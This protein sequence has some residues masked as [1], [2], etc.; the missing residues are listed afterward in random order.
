MDESRLAA[1]LRA[2]I[3]NQ[4]IYP[5]G[6][7]SVEQVVL[8]VHKELEDGL[9]DKDT[10]AVS[11]NG[12]RFYVEKKEVPNAGFLCQALEEHQIQGFT[13]E[14]GCTV[15]E[16]R[17]LVACLSEKRRPDRTF[18]DWLAAQNVTRIRVNHSRVLEVS[19]EEAVVSRGISQFHTLSSTAE[20]RGTLTGAL[21]FI[22]KIPEKTKKDALRQHLAERLVLM[23]ST[24]LKDLFE[25]PLPEG[26]TASGVLE[27][28]LAA[29]HQN[30]LMEIFNEV[31]RWDQRLKSAGGS[32]K[33]LA[34]EREKLKQFVGQLAKAPCALKVGRAVYE[35]LTQRGLLEAIPEGASGDLARDID[36][37]AQ[38]LLEETDDVFLKGVGPG[39][40]EFLND[41]FGFGLQARAKDVVQRLRSVLLEGDSGA[42]EK[43]AQTIRRILPLLWTHLRD[44]LFIR[45][46]DAL[47]TGA[48][49]E[50]T[51]GVNRE[52][53]GALVDGGRRD[54]AGAGKAR[55]RPGVSASY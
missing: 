33:D 17:A 50:R 27:D 34:A 25:K 12:N 29:M 51:I 39:L 9:R 21:D 48:E 40:P 52:I 6:S 44:D 31:R 20:M 53:L 32:A 1:R 55:G 42:R 15:E 38:R 49:A 43:S 54:F 3:M 30:K 41:L 2:A 8:T 35:D 46:R 26:E 14:T 45:L 18:G 4:R 22:D 36:T 16:V 10:L 19:E 13:F 28:V 24:M 47:L 7:R 5:T 11:R 37:E 23:E